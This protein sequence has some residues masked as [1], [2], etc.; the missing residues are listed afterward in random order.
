MRHALQA[1]HAPA[2]PSAPRAAGHRDAHLAAVT[3]D[4]TADVTA[5]VM[6]GATAE[7]WPTAAPD[8]G[9]ERLG[10]EIGWDHAHHRL[11]P[12]ADHLHGQHPV[13]QGWDA[14]RA[15]FGTRTLRPTR[16]VQRWL[17][18]RLQAWAAGIPFE[19]LMVTPHY[20]AQIEVL[21]CPVTREVLTQGQGLPTDA[22]VMRL[23]ADEAYAAG[24]LVVVS[25][26]VAQA[27]GQAGAAEVAGLV[28]RL[29]QQALPAALPGGLS[30]AQWERL[31]G[32]LSLAERAPYERLATRPLRVLPPNRVVLTNPSQALQVLLTQLLMG[33]GYAQ[34]QKA[35]AVL[36]P[37]ADAR[38]AFNLFMSALLAR[39]LAAGW[40]LDP[41][42]LRTALEDAWTQPVIQRRWEQLVLRL[43]R[44]ECERIVQAAARQGLFGGASRWL[45]DDALAQGWVP[46][47]REAA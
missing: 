26:R 42:R 5:P 45:G 24:H 41:Q 15:A 36:L 40:A 2:A 30:L 27:R 6:A 13:R 39:R 23:R 1:R 46:A 19:G 11:T 25:R 37:H 3:S 35:V 44:G 7:L 4:V 21:Q 10:F 8:N 20:L 28:A 12:P 22:T 9:F 47:A 33:E 29:H 43:T 17:A 14:G 16:A 34:R 18:L 32:L 31:S 38:R